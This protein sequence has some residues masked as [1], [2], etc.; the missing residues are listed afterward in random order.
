[1]LVLFRNL[2]DD[3][4]PEQFGILDDDQIVWCLCG[5][6]GCFEPDDYSIIRT[7]PNIDLTPSILKSTNTIGV[8]DNLEADIMYE[9]NEVDFSDNNKCDDSYNYIVDQLEIAYK[10]DKRKDDIS[11]SCEGY[12]RIKEILDGDCTDLSAAYFRILDVL[13]EEEKAMQQLQDKYD[14][15]VAI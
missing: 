15:E 6:D 10:P 5:C 12:N 3:N 14:S 11:L 7:F 13:S 4:E 8:R 9:L 2:L 1:M